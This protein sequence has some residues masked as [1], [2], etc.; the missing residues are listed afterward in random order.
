[1]R[2]TVAVLVLLAACSAGDELAPDPGLDAAPPD[3]EADWLGEFTWNVYVGAEAGA[4]I[5]IDGVERTELALVL[6]GEAAARTTAVVVENV[7]GGVVA[8]RATLRGDCDADCPSEDY[9]WTTRVDDLCAY[10]TGEIRFQGGLCESTH[11]ACFMDAWCLPKCGGPF[12]TCP[13]DL[14]CGLD[15]VDGDPTHGWHACVPI[16]TG[17]LGDACTIDAAGI[18][19]CGVALYCIDGVCA[20]ACNPDFQDCTS[21]STCVHVD[22]MANEVYACLS[23]R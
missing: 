19:D 15:R 7:V 16:G 22:G 1:V 9:G 5:R 3:A 21:P 10:A 17:A 4:V 20:P 18:D 8:S 12:T 11:G 23:P 14:R 13:T 6:D 2:G